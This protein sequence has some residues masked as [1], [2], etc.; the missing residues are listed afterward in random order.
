[1]EVKLRP[2]LYEFLDII[3]QFYYLVVFVASHERVSKLL[4]KKVDP[5]GIYFKDVLRQGNCVKLKTGV[6]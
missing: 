4:L 1:M 5:L 3:S 2:F 6:A